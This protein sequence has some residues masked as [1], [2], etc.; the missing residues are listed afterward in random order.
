MACC[1]EHWFLISLCPHS[2][3]TYPK[4][5]GRQYL[6]LPA[7]RSIAMKQ[8]TSCETD[9]HSAGQEITRL[10]WKPNAHYRVQ[11]RPPPVNTITPCL[12]FIFIT[13]SHL[14]LGL[15]SGPFPSRFPAPQ[16]AIFISS[17]HFPSLES[18]TAEELNM[19]QV[20]RVKNTRQTDRQTNGCT[21]KERLSNNFSKFPNFESFSGHDPEPVPLTSLR[22]ILMLSSHLLPIFQ[23]NERRGRDSTPAS[24]SAGPGFKSRAEHTSYPDWDCRSFP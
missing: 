10:L 23:V 18:T 17:C 12:W 5:R 1:K 3:S 20:L 13:L 8:S 9:S 6:T 16:Y 15:P 21:H 24:H 22:S 19:F 14:H 7:D 2:N 11:T 4:T